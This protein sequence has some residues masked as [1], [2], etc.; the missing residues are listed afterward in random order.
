[1]VKKILLI[2]IMLAGLL[3]QAAAQQITKGIWRGT[4]KTSSGHDIPFNFDVSDSAGRQLITIFN[5]TERFKVNDITYRGDSVFIQM[6]LYGNEFRLK[7]T[8]GGL[9]GKWI[10]LTSAGYRAMD[11]S[12]TPNTAWRFFKVSQTAVHNISGRWS[13]VFGTGAKIDT[14]VGEFIH[15]G[16]KLTGTFLTNTGDHRFLEGTVKGDSLYLSCFDG[17]NAYLFT[18]KINDEQTLTGGKFYSEYSSVT[19]WTAYKNDKAKLADAY[20]LSTLKPG[21]TSLDFSYPDLNGNKVSLSDERFKNKVV[22]IQILGSWCPNCIDETEY[23]VVHYYKKYQPRGVE[24]IGLAYERTNDV[25]KS[26]KAIQQFKARMGVPYP[27]LITGYTP[28]RAQTAKSLPMLTQVIAFPTTII[29]DK[30]GNVR[31]IHTG[32][33]GPATGAY[34][35]DYIKEFEALTEELLSETP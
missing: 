19:P 5:A 3:Y 27:L 29:I 21:Y 6:P 17:G 16:D 22:I 9:T 18:A 34:Y 26:A 25:V 30:K 13:A 2:V 1:M 12:A 10:K 4:L 11:F 28:A 15:T 33:N 35:T 20:S 31:K 14:A 8:S 7:K 24:I 23:L 32:F